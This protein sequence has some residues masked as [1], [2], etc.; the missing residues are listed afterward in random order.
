MSMR[1]PEESHSARLSHSEYKVTYVAQEQGSRPPRHV[2]LRTCSTLPS[3]QRRPR[4]WSLHRL[5]LQAGAGP[6]SAKIQVKFTIKCLSKC[7]TI[8]FINLALKKNIAI[9][10]DEEVCTQSL[11]KY[12]HYLSEDGRDN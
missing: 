10:S 5:V 12:T 3:E 7:L 2:T 4:L 8:F 1:S 6:E 9:N 11:I